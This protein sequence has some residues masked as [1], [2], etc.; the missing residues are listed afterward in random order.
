MLSKSSPY[1]DEFIS[2][3]VELRVKKRELKATEKKMLTL[4]K[5]FI[6]FEE[7]NEANE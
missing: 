2:V 5:Q 3:T 1:L 7:P 6:G 4:Q